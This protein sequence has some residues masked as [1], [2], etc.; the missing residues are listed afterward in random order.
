MAC[1]SER[2]GGP[3]L[4]ASSRRRTEAVLVPLR[5][6]NKMR[7]LTSADAVRRLS[8]HHRFAYCI[9][10]TAS[11]TVNGR[12]PPRGLITPLLLYQNTPTRPHPHCNFQTRMS[13]GLGPGA[14]AHKEAPWPGITQRVATAVSTLVSSA[15]LT[16]CLEIGSSWLGR[17]VSFTRDRAT[18][19]I[20][21]SE[22]ERERARKRQ[23]REGDRDTHRR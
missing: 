18:I 12:E 2:E 16:L 20:H 4:P 6:E 15:V 8:S 19:K 5:R 23:K 14:C 11:L 17:P 7:T 13:Y 3:T 21:P 9:R 10:T 22:R 1:V